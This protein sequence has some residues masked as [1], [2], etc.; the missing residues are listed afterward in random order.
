M[1]DR[2]D[3]VVLSGLEIASKE[4]P[5]VQGVGLTLTPGALTALVGSS[6]SGKTLT[7]R[8]LLGMV[9]FSPG[10]VKADLTVRIDG[11]EHRPYDAG[12]R[13]LVERAFRPLRG[14]VLGYLPQDTSM[15]VGI[16]FAKGRSADLVKKFQDKLMADAPA[17]LKEMKDKCGFDPINDIN[18]VIMTG[19]GN[20][21]LIGDASTCLQNPPPDATCV[22]RIDDVLN[23]ASDLMQTMADSGVENVV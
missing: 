5:L 16:S 21:V 13:R 14:G 20:D 11:V 3:A 19:G 17:E 18:T 12:K 6:G 4:R 22:E 1:S 7:T 9:D 23:A 15:V 2:G 8:S 10:V